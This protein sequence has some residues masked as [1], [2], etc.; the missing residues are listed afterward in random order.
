MTRHKFFFILRTFSSTVFSIFSPLLCTW[1]YSSGIA[2]S[3]ILE[4]V[5][6]L[7]YIL[8]SPGDLLKP[9]KVQV[10]LNLIKSYSLGVEYRYQE[11]LKLPGNFNVQMTLGTT[12]VLGFLDLFSVFFSFIVFRCTPLC[13]QYK[14]Q[15]HSKTCVSLFPSFDSP[16]WVRLQLSFCISLA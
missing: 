6:K 13:T 5:P 1:L 4:V 15:R 10:T 11:C 14:V 8:N 7:V 2:A 12:D 9:S 16:V 3:H